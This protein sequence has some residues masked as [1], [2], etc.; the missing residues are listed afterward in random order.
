[1]AGL[2]DDRDFPA[3]HKAA[4]QLTDRLQDYPEFWNICGITLQELKRL[5]DAIAAFQKAIV[6]EPN[7]KKLHFNLA[8]AYQ[9]NRQNEMAIQS[10]EDTI[11]LSP[12]WAKAHYRKAQNLETLSR[13]PEAIDAYKQ[14]VDLEPK[15]YKFHSA[16]GLALLKDDKAEESLPFFSSAI[17]YN[18]SY[19]SGYF[20]LG[21]ALKKIERLEDATL[22]YKKA[23]ELKPDFY[24]AWFNQGNTLLQLLNF[25]KSMSCFESCLSLKPNDNKA[26]IKKIQ[27]S[28]GLGHVEQAISQYQVL[29]S[30]FPKNAELQF[31]VGK[32]RASQGEMSVAISHFLT[33][34]RLDPK[35]LGAISGLAA[36]P[37]GSLDTL[38]LQRLKNDFSSIKSQISLRARH[39]ISAGILKQLGQY[40]DAWDQ[41]VL[42]NKAVIEVSHKD[43]KNTVQSQRHSL[44][45][46][47]AK[48]IPRNIQDETWPTSLFVLGPSRS[49]KTTIE[50]LLGTSPSVARGYENPPFASILQETV[51]DLQ[52][53]EMDRLWQLPQEALKEFLNRYQKNVREIC[54]GRSI[55]T[56][57][58]PHRILDAW[59][60][61][62]NI[63]NS[64]FVFMERD[65]VDT[66]VAI[67]QKDYKSGNH[68]AYHP[69]TIRDHLT[70]Y[71]NM[72]E[73]LGDKFGQRAIVIRHEAFISD[74]ERELSR[75]ENLLNSTL[76]CNVLE[77]FLTHQV[78]NE[79][80]LF[81]S[82]FNAM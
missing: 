49:G 58:S 82:Y 57:T 6:L 50:R 15:N 14:A 42:A 31:Q 67:F 51:R 38:S 56:D 17:T 59:E 39:F 4:S 79:K 37:E 63:P 40:K 19:A 7:N 10:L 12:N 18:P 41:Y 43:A 46:C 81:R 2:L 21:N 29:L 13:L 5:T 20:N 53:A 78:N 73:T 47:Q 74:P 34:S 30:N 22:C 25:S 3:L 72:Q 62:D 61:A 44:N 70:W 54:D 33:A 52:L 23:T 60:I 1:M 80:N 76:K 45:R 28:I 75:I 68:Y 64:Y 11:R 16:L 9:K 35:H 65:P 66:A 71:Q 48:P 26:S 55:F 36:L 32:I 27:A 69:V 8:L 24:E 77:N